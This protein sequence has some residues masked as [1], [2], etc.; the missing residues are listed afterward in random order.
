MHH[1]QHHY[2]KPFEDSEIFCPLDARLDHEIPAALALL[3]EI[4][5]GL[6]DRFVVG[7]PTADSAIVLAV[8]RLIQLDLR[9]YNGLEYLFVVNGG[10]AR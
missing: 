8:A 10:G 4:K 3:D 1:K 5:H 6:C 9:N 2:N 7:T